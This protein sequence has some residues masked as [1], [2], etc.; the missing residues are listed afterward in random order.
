MKKLLLLTVI[1]AVTAF[2]VGYLM[3]SQG[4]PWAAFPDKTIV[5]SPEDRQRIN[6]P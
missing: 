5:D 3:R 6:T 4:Q 2:A 1:L